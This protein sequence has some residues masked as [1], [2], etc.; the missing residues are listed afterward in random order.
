MLGRYWHL[1][2]AVCAASA[3]AA[4]LPGLT[5]SEPAN[6]EAAAP[7]PAPKVVPRHAPRATAVSLSE[8]ARWLESR[9]A[10]LSG[11][12]IRR[13]DADAGGS[14]G[15]FGGVA[16]A[17]AQART[18]RGWWRW[19]GS[20][21]GFGG[22]TATLASFPISAAITAA[23]AAR[24]PGQGALLSELLELG[25]ADERCA[26]MLHLAVERLRGRDSPLAPWIALLPD[27][28][29]TPLFWG[30]EEVSWLRGTALHRATE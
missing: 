29:Q 7:P 1:G 4:A 5:P 14:G 19:A 24:D 21:V 27:E 22:G 17:Q 18:A 3:A 11:I 10:D 26:V 20:W 2:G 8:L 15:R 30:R 28:F 16:S 25:V 23:A 6:C 13:T 9:G 12:D